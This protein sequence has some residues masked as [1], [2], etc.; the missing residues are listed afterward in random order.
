[1][2]LEDRIDRMEHRLAAMETLV[3]QLVAGTGTTPATRP[4]A[5]PLPPPPS[6]SRSP[7]PVPAPAVETPRTAA[8]PV[9]S[10][11]W[12]GQRVFLGIGVIALL[13]AA[14]YLL[15]LSFERGWVSPVVRCVGGV[16]AGIAVGGVGWR[17]HPRYRVYGAAVIGCGAGIIYLSVWAAARLY[18]VVPSATGIVG[19]ASVSIALAMIAYAIEVEALGTV[20]AL[21]AFLAPVL[22]G[23]EAA[24]ADLLLLYIGSM[25]V[26]LGLVAAR[27]KWRLTALVVAASYFGVGIEGAGD[28]AVPWGVLVYGLLG[29]SAGLFLGLRE[30]W[31]ETR[32]LS[33]SGGWGLI[34][35]ASQRL[36]TQWLVLGAGLVLAAPVWWHGIRWP[37]PLPLH[38]GSQGEGPGWSAGEELYF[39]ATPMLVGWA[40]YGLA[41]ARF[42]HAP[43]LLPFLI[44]V[45]Y[46]V[47]GYV[48]PR[49]AFAIVGAA[50]AGLA[51]MQRW[52]GTAEVWALLG[53]GVFWPA[54]DRVFRRTD[55]RWYGLITLGVAAASLFGRVLDQRTAADAAFVG[56]WALAL[57]GTTATVAV[58]AAGLWTVDPDRE[59]TRLIGAGLWV[60][61]GAMLLLGATGEIDRYFALRSAVHADATLAA[62]LGVSAWWLVFAATLVVLGFSRRLK[63]VRLG[64]LLVAGLAVVKVVVFDLSSLDAL[65]RVGSVFLLGVVAL[66][67]AYLYYRFDQDDR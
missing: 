30:R 43:G 9:T 54:L 11:R 52:D 4:I 25:A 38:W 13:L 55:G 62:G 35:A 42:D 61:S 50:A 31:W 12:I 66:S 19:L 57:W 65:Y 45:P 16:I 10:E 20:A 1:M 17:V 48:K 39:F 6:L 27:R 24:N 44:S 23:R 26:G 5:A 2:S 3:R 58:F 28:R 7:A 34:A 47:T 64:G 59:D 41:P 46:L 29:G 63:P 22:V 51:A 56:P 15:K 14:G 53:L 33:F 37:R 8:P 32:L 67:L 40:V 60:V 21:G 18:G 36:A 49:S